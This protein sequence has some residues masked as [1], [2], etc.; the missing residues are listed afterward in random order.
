MY[1]GINRLGDVLSALNEFLL[2]QNF[3]VHTVASRAPHKLRNFEILVDF[4]VEL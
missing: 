2:I 4:S 3:A 1:A